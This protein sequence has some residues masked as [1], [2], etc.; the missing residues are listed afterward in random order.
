MTEAAATAAGQGSSWSRRVRSPAS[1]RTGCASCRKLVP[2]AGGGSVGALSRYV[3]A[4]LT[5]VDVRS[6]KLPTRRRGTNR[7][8]HINFLLLPWSLQVRESDF[9][10][11]QDSQNT[12]T[13]EPSGL[14][15]FSP[16]EPLDLDLLDRVLLGAH[17]EVENV[18]VVLLP[19]SAVDE[20]ELDDIEALLAQHGVTGI[21]AGV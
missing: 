18:D 7:V 11:V 12:T 17:E 9:R 16:S 4:L 5:S 15:E 8:D 14:F 19:E 6:H 2:P 1:R 10:V 20:A 13:A 21:H 3:C